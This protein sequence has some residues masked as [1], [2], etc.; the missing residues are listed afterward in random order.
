MKSLFFGVVAGSL[1]IAPLSFAQVRY[2]FQSLANMDTTSAQTFTISGVLEAAQAVSNELTQN[3][4]SNAS[5]Y[6]EKLNSYSSSS[7][8]SGADTSSKQKTSSAKTYICTI[9]CKSGS[10]PTTTRE[11]TAASRRAAA[12]IAGDNANQIC[13]SSGLSYASSR[14]FPENQCR[15]K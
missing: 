14:S 6:R 5:A 4:R 7:S 1:L 12:D 13:Q 3:A 10:G 9:Y 15:E 8:S 2:S 11:I